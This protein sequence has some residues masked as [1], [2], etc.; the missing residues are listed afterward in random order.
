MPGS[1]RFVRLERYTAPGS[2]KRMCLWRP[3]YKRCKRADL[4]ILKRSAEGTLNT[5]QPI[6]H[7]WWSCWCL[8]GWVIPIIIY[9]VWESA[10]K[11]AACWCWYEP[12]IAAVF[13]VKIGH[14]CVGGCI[15]TCT[16][17]KYDISQ[18][19]CG[20]PLYYNVC[21]FCNVKPSCESTRWRLKLSW[22]SIWECSKGQMEGEMRAKG[23]AEQ[24]RAAMSAE[25]VALKKA[26]FEL[27]G[28]VGVLILVY[29]RWQQKTFHVTCMTLFAVLEFT[30]ANGCMASK[31]WLEWMLVCKVIFTQKLRYCLRNFLYEK[32]MT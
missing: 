2:W 27:M 15:K 31:V 20:C 4:T 7:I 3:H 24:M 30:L 28:E 8:N 10:I 32:Y 18:H 29:F 6:S 12:S 16:M 9:N 21:L 11:K 17:L 25:M 14:A 22:T 26:N 1:L 13:L 5:I 19:A 23:E